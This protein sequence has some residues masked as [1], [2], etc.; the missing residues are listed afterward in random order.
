MTEN[1]IETVP[2]LSAVRAIPA[3]LAPWRYKR[4]PE[5]E[6]A[7][8]T[9]DTDQALSLAIR[10]IRHGGRADL[11]QGVQD[12]LGEPY[13]GTVGQLIPL[14]I[15]TYMEEALYNYGVMRNHATVLQKREGGSLRVPIQDGQSTMTWEGESEAIASNEPTIT[16]G[17]NLI[18]KKLAMVAKVSN[19]MIEDSAFD[20]ASWLLRDAG[21]S[22]A[23]EED[24]Q[25]YSVNA[26]LT[27]PEALEE[28]ATTDQTVLEGFYIETATQAAG[29]V[30]DPTLIGYLHLVE[31]FYA[32]PESE[33]AGAIWAGGSV[34]AQYL[35]QILDTALRPILRDT[36]TGNLEILGHP[37]IE[38]PA[39]QD[40]GTT[41][42]ER[43]NRLYFINM[44]RSYII[45]DDEIKMAR[46]TVGG[47]AFAEDMTYF[48]FTHRTMGK[49]V[50]DNQNL[51]T[52]RPAVN[53][54]IY[55][56]AIN[57]PAVTP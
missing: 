42:T 45:L 4:L 22:M 6:R 57:G 24:L 26:G 25:M 38:F 51:T 16:L 54:Y 20:L 21:R 44:P 43:Q 47:A 34:V 14:S 32:L 8:R 49:R 10:T 52:L 13:D 3:A 31:M 53:P 55:T 37:F 30:D 15:S 27:A 39:G 50:V 46:T 33:R 23:L 18:L 12:T 36:G 9:P 56:G 35:S 29:N 11:L 1:R 40:T 17:I 41:P 5:W 7:F 2:A 19:E 28:K 48:R